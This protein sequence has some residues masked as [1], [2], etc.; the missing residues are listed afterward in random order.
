MAAA[1]A[2]LLRYCCAAASP[3]PA[4]GRICGH[5]CCL[6]PMEDELLVNFDS[7]SDELLS[8]DD[9]GSGGGEEG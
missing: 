4:F 5:G 2:L 6:G 8:N 1:T 3:A 7:S 9:D